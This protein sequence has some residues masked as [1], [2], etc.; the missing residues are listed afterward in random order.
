MLPGNLDH[1]L[2][3]RSAELALGLG[4]TIRPFFELVSF[5]EPVRPAFL[6]L[7]PVHLWT[8]NFYFPSLST[9]KAFLIVL[10]Y[11][12]GF[13]LRDGLN[14]GLLS[15][16]TSHLFHLTGPPRPGTP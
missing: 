7:F 8:S 1:L 14:H 15:P 6:L 16:A 9:Y 10:D 11:R 12:S 4:R 2:V 5:T 13:F 3:I